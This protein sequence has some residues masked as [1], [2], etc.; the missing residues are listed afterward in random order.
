MQRRLNGWLRLWI[1]V[2]VIVWSIGGYFFYQGVQYAP[3]YAASRDAIC[4]WYDGIFPPGVYENALSRC[5]S[6]ESGF[7]SAGNAYAGYVQHHWDTVWTQLAFWGLLPVALAVLGLIASVVGKWVWRGF[8]A[9][10]NDKPT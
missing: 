6:E 2:A 4:V 5:L 9:S 1:V 7:E 3:P 10:S 8:K